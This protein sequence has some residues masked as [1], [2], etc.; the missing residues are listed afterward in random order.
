MLRMDYVRSAEWV[1]PMTGQ[2]YAI[3][4]NRPR[5]PCVLTFQVAVLGFFP[6][7]RTSWRADFSNFA[8]RL[9]S[10]QGN[11]PH[12]VCKVWLSEFGRLA[13]VRNA[14]NV[15]TCAYGGRSQRIYLLLI[16]TAAAPHV[17]NYVLYIAF[18]LRTNSLLT[19]CETQ[20]RYFHVTQNGNYSGRVFARK[21][22]FGWELIVGGMM[23][24]V[25]CWVL[26]MGGMMPSVRPAGATCA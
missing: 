16:A 19:P 13:E 1:T 17:A 25:P 23:P 21:N 7:N 11:V 4:R 8:R 12:L 3:P 14:S 6:K 26:I 2:S 10:L 5:L 20:V 15:A 24:S 22:Q 18:P 9:G